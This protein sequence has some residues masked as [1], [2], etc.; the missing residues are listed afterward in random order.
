MR[1]SPLLPP[2]AL[3]GALTLA[4]AD[5]PS[6]TAPDS[7]TSPS[8]RAEHETAFFGVPFGNDRYT[9]IVGHTF[10]DMVAICEHREPS[11]HAWNVLTVVR[12]EGRGDFEESLKQLTRGKNLPITVFEFSPFEFGNE[13]PLLDAPHF[14][15][16]GRAFFNDNDLNLTHRGANSFNF[17]ASATLT[18]ESGRR[19]HF[20]MRI[21]QVLSQESTLEPEHFVFLH[22]PDF[23]IKLT[24]TGR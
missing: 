8:F 19:Y 23:V 16:T 6:P 17:R 15:G 24:P 22:S 7:P 10:E 14:E 20:M 2:V 4:C 21:H 9:V 3:A 5:R 13:C 18:D 12:P 11:F 1:R